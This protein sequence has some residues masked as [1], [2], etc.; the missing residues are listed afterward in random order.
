MLQGEKEY[1]EAIDALRLRKV[2]RRV[3]YIGE[4]VL[5]LGDCREVLPALATGSI[6]MIFTDPPYGHNN[7]NG[8][9]IE[10]REAALGR[11]AKNAA[12]EARPIAGDGAEANELVA[13]LFS[14]ASRLLAGGGCCCCCCGGGGPDPQFARW[15][16]LMDDPLDFKQ[17]VVWDKGPMG[18]GWQ[19][20]RSY[21]TVLVGQ[22]RGAACKWHDQSGR[23]EN[24]IRPGKVNKI[25]PG[26][27]QHP[28][29][30]PPELSEF[31]MLLHSQRGETVLDPFM[32]G[33]STAIGAHRLDRRFIGVEIEE[34][35][36]DMAYA[37]LRTATTEPLF[38][39]IHKPAG[40]EAT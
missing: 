33:G 16:M 3:E 20:R 35:W 34:R 36:F 9:L 24:I 25:I 29:P 38:D 26:K 1:R 23:I 15:A 19:Y 37:R 39:R 21:E 8:D 11:P 40:M 17:M 27:E 4:H 5:I 7:N 13:G 6:D 12:A 28:T 18:M 2:A 14:E 22:K 30:K 31:F 10:R 32:G